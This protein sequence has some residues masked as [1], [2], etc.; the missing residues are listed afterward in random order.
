MFDWAPRLFH[1][2]RRLRNHEQGTESSFHSL[3]RGDALLHA[4]ELP[5]LW[6]A[7]RDRAELSGLTWL[8]STARGCRPQVFLGD[9]NWYAGNRAIAAR[10]VTNQKANA[11]RSTT[12]HK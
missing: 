12:T 8:H 1:T 4:P 2:Q 10:F 3:P 11:Q 5:R 9:P 6:N 7:R